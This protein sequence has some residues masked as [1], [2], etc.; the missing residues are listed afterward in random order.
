MDLNHFFSYASSLLLLA[1]MVVMVSGQY[2]KPSL[3]KEKLLS[4]I[5]GIQGIV[6]CKSGRKVTPLEGSVAR[7]TCKTVDENGFEAA[8]ITI[9][10]DAT[11]AKGYFLATISPF[12]IQNKKKKLTQCKAS[13]ELSPLDSCNVLTDANNGISGAL[14]TSYHLLPEKNMKLFTVGPFVCTSETK[15]VDNGY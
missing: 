6:Y 3:G 14:L 1:V 7:I 13:L 2:E 8:P 15:P 9:L 10:S 11:D 5:V 4:T 12:E